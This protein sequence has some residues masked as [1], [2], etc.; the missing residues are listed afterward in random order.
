MGIPTSETMWHWIKIF[1]LN[2]PDSHE[3][4]IAPYPSISVIPL[5]RQHIITSSV[6]Q[7]GATSVQLVSWLVAQ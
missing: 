6:N 4:T 3:Y 2:S 5:T 7:L 1:C